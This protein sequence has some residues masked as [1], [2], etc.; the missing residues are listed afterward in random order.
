MINHFFLNLPVW[1]RP[2]LLAFSFRVNF[3]SQNEHLYGI[4]PIDRGGGRKKMK[5]AGS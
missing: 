5:L 3:F 1:I 4:S 2:C